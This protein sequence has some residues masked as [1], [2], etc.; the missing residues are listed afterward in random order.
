VHACVLLARF[1]GSPREGQGVCDVRVSH[2]V[3]VCVG[4][5]GVDKCESDGVLALKI[6]KRT[7]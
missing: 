6:R 7:W 5:G 2:S 1:K 4:G 3:C